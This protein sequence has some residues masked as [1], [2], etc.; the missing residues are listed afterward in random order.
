MEGLYRKLMPMSDGLNYD[1]LVMEL[2]LRHL[3][4]SA[5]LEYA[6]MSS[7]KISIHDLYREFAGLEAQ[8]KLNALDM[9]ERRWVYARDALPTELVDEPRSKVETPIHDRIRELITWE[10]KEHGVK[11]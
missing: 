3:V 1:C 11:S 6:E 10:C 4:D 2:Q 5:L 8:E 9:E 7:R